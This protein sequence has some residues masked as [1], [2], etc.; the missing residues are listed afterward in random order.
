MI[1]NNKLHAVIAETG[2]R[3][4]VC[5]TNEAKRWNLLDTMTPSKVK[6][7]PYNSKVISVYGISRCAVSF[8]GTSVAAEWHT[9]S[10]SCEP[11]LSGDKAL[12][13]GIINFNAKPST[14]QPILRIDKTF[15]GEEKEGLQKILAD[16]TENFVKLH[17]D[18]DAKPV[19]VPPRITP[20]HLKDRV[21]KAIKDM[22]DQDVI[23][24]HPTNQPAPWISCALI[25][26]KAIGDIRV[27]LDSR[28]LNKAIQS[29]NLPMPIHED[30]KA[31][32]TGNEIF[33]KWIFVVH[34]GR[35]SFIQILGI[36]QYYMQTT[37]YINTNV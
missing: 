25:A 20:Y 1:I 22:I 32:L 9:I 8:G 3:L 28:N 33:S 7:K 16:F 15:K 13:M 30:I 23:E 24:E 12:Q 21:D 26:P 4:S 10:G 18:P 19:I 6:I 27:T 2:S 34:S 11:I 17:V 14:F 35:L 31:K 29:T 36:L 37:S 5:G